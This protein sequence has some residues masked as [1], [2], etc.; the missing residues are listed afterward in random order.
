MA[1][2]PIKGLLFNGPE[3]PDTESIITQHVGADL[4]LGRIDE[5]TTM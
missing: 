2:I 3:N 4:V 1:Q 5:L